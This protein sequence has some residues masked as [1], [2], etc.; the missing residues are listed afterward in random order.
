MTHALTKQEYLTVKSSEEKYRHLFDKSPVGIYITDRRGILLNVNPAFL[1][2]LRYSSP[3]DLCGKALESFFVDPKDWERYLRILECNLSIKEFGTRLINRDGGI[4]DVS[5]TAA[6]RN[7]IT[8]K[9]SGFEGF[10]I[11]TTELIR[12]QIE[13]KKTEDK[14]RTV[15]EN[16]LAGIYMFQEGGRFTYVNTRLVKMLGYDGPDEIIGEYFW[17]FVHP[18]D[19]EIVK[20]RGL[21]REKKDFYPHHYTF[22]VLSKKGETIWVDMRSSRATYMGKPAVVGNFINI[23]RIKKA[24]EQIRDLSRKLINV[25]EEERKSLAADLHDEF[26]QSLTSLK[27]DVEKLHKS[28]LV[29][30]SDGAEACGR[31][32]EKISD[33]ADI[34]RATTSKLR[35]DILD[36]LGLI[37]SLEWYI[38][39]LRKNRPNIKISFQTLG[40][41]KRQEPAIEIT[42]YRVFQE[43]VTNTLKHACAQNITLR[44]TYIHPDVIF[45]CLDDGCG[46]NALNNG[47]PADKKMG[48]GLLSMKE[49]VNALNGKFMLK[50]SP[51]N[52]T[53]IRVELPMPENDKDG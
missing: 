4:I 22:R 28:L 6:I 29:D 7:G 19:R 2:L 30:A 11:D 43:S 47:F 33:L 48:I 53:I 24:E 41:K 32:I 52:G 38:E 15:L 46:F 49:R 16:S 14:Y 3:N 20:K 42:L 40:F 37:P 27:F 5:M 34:I 21:D 13:Q 12:N 25:I 35:P 17:K 45:T 44:L 23:T 8:G 9:V 39:K 36:H 50:S 26:G 18:D 1:E 51:G 10:I 31:L